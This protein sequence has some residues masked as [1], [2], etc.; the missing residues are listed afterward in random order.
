MTNTPT[1]GTV[2]HAATDLWPSLSL[3]NWPI[4]NKRRGWTRMTETLFV[5][6]NGELPFVN[7]RG[8]RPKEGYRWFPHLGVIPQK[9]MTEYRFASEVVSHTELVYAGVTLR[10][11]ADGLRCGEVDE[12]DL[13]RDTR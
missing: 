1:L 11:M 5:A 9:V 12:K 10:V 2:Q 13:D 6:K 3:A 4:G 7:F 8:Q